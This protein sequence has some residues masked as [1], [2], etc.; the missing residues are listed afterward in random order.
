MNLVDIAI[1]M[2]N[3]ELKYV[4][5][6]VKI[7]IKVSQLILYYSKNVCV[8]Y[9]SGSIYEKLVGFKQER[10]LIP[11]PVDRNSASAWLYKQTWI[12]CQ[13][14]KPNTST[15]HVACA[16]KLCSIV[17]SSIQPC[18]GDWVAIGHVVILYPG[19]P[20]I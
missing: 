3:L 13:K 17:R 18:P 4:I 2:G 7:N 16:S 12:I 11:A 8:V 20:G 14:N 10:H 5:I 1:F 6:S 15:T 9:S 19:C